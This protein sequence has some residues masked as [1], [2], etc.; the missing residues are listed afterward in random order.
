MNIPSLN[1]SER[2][3]DGY[4]ATSTAHSTEGRSCIAERDRLDTVDAG[5]KQK[6]WVLLATK[7]TEGELLWNV[8]GGTSVLIPFPTS[9]SETGGAQSP[10]TVTTNPAAQI[11]GQ[12][13]AK[14]ASEAVG[15]PATV[16]EVEQMAEV[17]CLQLQSG[18]SV[19]EIKTQMESGIGDGADKVSSLIDL[20]VSNRC[21]R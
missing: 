14:R 4:V 12:E 21:P 10:I 20:I 8:G 9:T 2:D 6:G 13:L 15:E 18:T 19:D 11:S 3:P 7:A 1:I 5:T 17:V 16:Q